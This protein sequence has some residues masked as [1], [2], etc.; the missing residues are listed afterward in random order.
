MIGSK[1]PRYL[2]LGLVLGVAVGAV[3]LSMF[4]TQYRLLAGDIL[5][6]SAAEHDAYL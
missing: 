5:A 2:I 1:I 6:K 3:M 4:Y